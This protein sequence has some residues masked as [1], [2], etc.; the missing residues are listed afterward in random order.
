MPVIF[1][2]GYDSGEATARAMKA[3]AVAFL[4]KP[5]DVDALLRA[6][7][8]AIEA[9]PRH[10]WSRRGGLKN[11]CES[12]ALM[13]PRAM[14]EFIVPAADSTGSGHTTS[15]SQYGA[16]RSVRREKCRRL[17]RERLVKLKK[18]PMSGVRIH[19][20]HGVRKVLDQPIRVRDGDHFVA[21]AVDDERRLVDALEIGEAGLRRL[22]PLPERRHLCGDDVRS[23]CRVEV[24]CCVVQASQ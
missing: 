21:N 19:E 10:A 11:S 4:T 8:H 13:S 23:G 16:R 1:M 12:D 17:P 9:Q 18:G 24:L 14:S 2:S 3:G 6:I 5:L 15:C 20:K 7:E 22:L